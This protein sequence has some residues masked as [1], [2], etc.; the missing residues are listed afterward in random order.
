MSPS[1]RIVV[2]LVVALAVTSQ[3]PVC[4]KHGDVVDLSDACCFEMGTWAKQMDGI[5][6]LIDQQHYSTTSHPIEGGI[7]EDRGRWC[8]L[9]VMAY[10]QYVVCE[11]RASAKMLFISNNVTV[12]CEG[13][14]E[15]TS[16]G[17]DYPCLPKVCADAREAQLLLL[18]GSLQEQNCQIT[19]LYG[20]I[21]PPWYQSG[22]NR[23]QY[24]EDDQT[25]VVLLGVVAVILLLAVGIYCTFVARKSKKLITAFP[26]E[27][28]TAGSY[29]DDL[30]LTTTQTQTQAQ[31]Q[32]QAHYM[33]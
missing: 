20:N 4:R 23:Q 1:L 30:E 8:D 17:A 33:T 21:T 16:V 3:S 13:S 31:A 6:K 10:D 22:N 32:A 19:K 11:C 7:L 28:A 25:L 2:S 9:N 24:A 5:K 15:D 29:Q 12:R 14:K 27:P 26:S 18:N